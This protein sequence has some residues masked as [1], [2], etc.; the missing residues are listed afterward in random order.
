MLGGALMIVTAAPASIVNNDEIPMVP[1][2]KSR[3]TRLLLREMKGSDQISAAR[4][5]PASH[6]AEI[7]R[8]CAAAANG[9][10]F[11]IRV[12]GYYWCVGL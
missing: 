12:S 3:F 11:S 8:L 7:R 9:L 5:S 2:T 10:A 1:R 6:G 4:P